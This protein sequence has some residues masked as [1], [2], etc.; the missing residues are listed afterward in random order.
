MRMLAKYLGCVRGGAVGARVIVTP[1]KTTRIRYNGVC[2][3]VL[4]PL[5]R[6]SIYLGTRF[7]SMS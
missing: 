7:S 1:R 2:I 4:S 6:V 5:Y 3:S